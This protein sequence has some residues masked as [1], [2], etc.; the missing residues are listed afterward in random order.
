MTGA[1]ITLE[2]QDAPLQA[3]LARLAQGASDLTPLM[4][5]I[6][7][8]ILQ[9]VSRRFETGRGPNGVWWRP[10]DRALAEGG[11]DR[12]SWRALKREERAAAREKL[13]QTLVDT[14]HLRDSIVM[15]AGPDSVTVGTNVIYA[16][17]HQFGGKIVPK[18]APH[19]VFRMWDGQLVMT[20]EVTIPD[21]PFLGIDQ[22]DRDVIGE[23]LNAWATSLIDGVS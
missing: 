11:Y 8:D 14:G 23:T 6:G 4:E 19:L 18:K 20:D 7:V 1:A 2:V 15:E 5:A 9:S 13:G 16:A 10:S 12:D 3:A 22:A 21:R 17:I